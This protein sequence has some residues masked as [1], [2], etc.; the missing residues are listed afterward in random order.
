MLDRYG[1]GLAARYRVHEGWRAREVLGVTAGYRMK[2]CCAAP[3]HE[4]QWF[5]CE[6]NRSGRA[7]RPAAQSYDACEDIVTVV[8]PNDAEK[9]PRIAPSSISLYLA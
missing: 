4:M 2:A 7:L 8:T 3:V 6:E 9:R 1:S 5:T